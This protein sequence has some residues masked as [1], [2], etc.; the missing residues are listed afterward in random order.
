MKI[1][2]K[3]TDEGGNLHS[4]VLKDFPHLNN[5]PLILWA[6]VCGQN[7]NVWNFYPT[8]NAA[9]INCSPSASTHCY[10]HESLLIK[11]PITSER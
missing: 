8:E 6:N 10:I 4:Y 7:A 11:K 1:E 2:I 9:V 3:L 5:A